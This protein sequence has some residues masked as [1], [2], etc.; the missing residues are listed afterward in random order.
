VQYF[1][2]EA[3]DV[4]LGKVTLSHAVSCGRDCVAHFMLVFEE[5]QSDV[6]LFV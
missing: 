3:R 5:L 6:V 4:F 1:I 2:N